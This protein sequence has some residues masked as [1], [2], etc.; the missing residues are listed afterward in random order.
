MCKTSCLV[1]NNNKLKD[2]FSNFSVTST[3]MHL[4]ESELGGKSLILINISARESDILSPL[5][6]QSKIPLM[7]IIGINNC[8]KIN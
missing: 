1:Q 3:C 8:S 7:S 5:D 2:L 4:P 6:K